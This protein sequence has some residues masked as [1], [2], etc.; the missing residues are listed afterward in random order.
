VLLHCAAALD[1]LLLRNRTAGAQTSAPAKA[2]TFEMAEFIAKYKDADAAFAQAL[3]AVAK[4][5]AEAK[6]RREP[7]R[8]VLDLEKHATY[9]I[10]RPIE[11]TQLDT[12][13]INGNGAVI[14]N[15]SFQSTLQIKSSSH[16]TFRDFSIDYDPLPFTQGTVAAIA[17]RTLDITV[18]VDAGYP[19]DA[20]F[21]ATIQGGFFAVMDRRTRAL[22]AGARSFLEP[23]KVEPAGNGLIKVH[24]KWSANDLGPGQVPLVVGDTVAIGTTYAHAVEVDGSTA[25]QFIGI[26]VRASPAMGIVESG[27]PGAMILQRVAIAPGPKPMGAVMDRLIST[28]ADGTHFTAVERGPAIDGCS[29]AN[30]GDDAVNVH[31]FYFFVVEKTAA[32]AYRLSPKWDVGMQVGDSVESSENGTFRSLGQSKIVALT[33]K[34]APELKNKIAQIWK[35][36]SPTTLPDT[37]YEV[38]LQSELPLKV[39]DA[40]TSLSRIGSGT[41]VRNSSFHAC[42][43]VMVKSPD[44]VIENNRFGYSIGVAIHVG[45]DIGFWAES[46][47]AR[48]MVISNNTFTQCAIGGNNLFPDNNG[49]GTIYVGMTPP[50]NAKGFQRNFENRNVAIEANRIE[51]SFVYAIFITN[52]DGVKIVGNQIGRTFIRGSAF[53]AG[54]LYGIKPGSAIFIGMSRNAEISNNVVAKG[55]VTRVP[56]TVDR[57]CPPGTVMA[58]GNT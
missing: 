12:L 45:S 14:V 21:L 40:L 53:A 9:R 43:R 1:V 39:G 22:K 20:K 36:K 51:E 56:V 55:A 4:A 35:G 27:G 47:F 32:R 26:N 3:A 31:G 44:S 28:N 30:T 41:T 33:K 7:P 49:L 38:E 42:G 57:T 11:V 37:I 16:V 34:K 50:L 2:I 23:A 52:A 54:Q 15:T 19:D 17:P 5:T 25:T 29:F 48:N 58:R 10:K 18:K 6:E 13:E 46:G 24:L 8:F